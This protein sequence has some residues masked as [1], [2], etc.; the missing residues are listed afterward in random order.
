MNITTFH[1]RQMGSSRET[2]INTEQF[3]DQMKAYL[4]E[5]NLLHS[6]SLDTTVGPHDAVYI[7]CLQAPNESIRQSAW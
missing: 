3:E 5:H 6:L 4:S 1:I 2:Q 7:A